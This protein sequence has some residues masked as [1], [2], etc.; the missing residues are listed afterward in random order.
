[1]T[2]LPDELLFKIIDYNLLK[3]PILNKS[4]KKYYD[5]KL[6]YYSNK[7]KNWYKNHKLKLT[8]EQVNNTTNF[9]YTKK[10]ILKIWLKYF[11]LDFLKFYAGFIARSNS[12]DSILNEI[13][14]LNTK[15]EAYIFFKNINLSN[16]IY[17][18]SP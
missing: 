8:Y 16:D 7:I 18:N 17:Q 3:I 13:S 11:G 4:H 15:Y 5:K 14:N 6:A 9:L 2:N 10:T 12:Q 1:M